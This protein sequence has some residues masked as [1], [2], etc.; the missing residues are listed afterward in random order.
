MSTLPTELREIFAGAAEQDDADATVKSLKKVKE[1]ELTAALGTAGVL[2]LPTAP[3][4]AFSHDRPAPA[5]QADFT[6]LA[7][8]AGLPAIAIP[9]GF[10][11]DGLP[12]S[13]QLVGPPG[14]EPGLIALGRQL[15]NQLQAYRRPPQSGI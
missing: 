11:D 3:Q 5:N 7:N 14:S 9:A 13:V 4:T 2:L 10:S 12:V 15:D 8:I 6:G 1:A